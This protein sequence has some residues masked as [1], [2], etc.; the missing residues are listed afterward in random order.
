MEKPSGFFQKKSLPCRRME[1]K[2]R[3]TGLM[4][5]SPWSRWDL[6]PFRVFRFFSVSKK[7]EVNGDWLGGSLY[8]LLGNHRKK[9]SKILK[10]MKDLK[11]WCATE[12]WLTSWYGK[13]MY[14]H[15]VMIWISLLSQL[16]QKF[17]TKSGRPR[18]RLVWDE[19]SRRRLLQDECTGRG[20][21]CYSLARWINHGLC[22][23][24]FFW[25]ILDGCF[26]GK[27]LD[28]HGNPYS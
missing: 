17:W 1:I 16:V 7:D 20:D 28:S 21:N 3:P 5:S 8:N 10:L 26:F 12:I 2:S 23:W 19:H 11:N 9:A 24:Y 14:S 22:F 27:L 6:Q 25:F 15:V 4:R 13:Y 18:K